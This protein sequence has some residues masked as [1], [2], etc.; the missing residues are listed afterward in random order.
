MID[1]TNGE[2]YEKVQTIP[3]FGEYDIVVAGGGV[4]GFGAAVAA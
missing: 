1:Y 3:L 2:I 4:A